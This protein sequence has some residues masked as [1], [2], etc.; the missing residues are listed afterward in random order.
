MECGCDGVMVC[1]SA[2]VWVCGSAGVMGCW[3]DGVRVCWGDEVPLSFPRRRE[4]RPFKKDKRRGWIPA[5]AG[6]TK[7]KS[8][9]DKRKKRE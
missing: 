3:G 4:S 6:M 5:S 9:N 7:E 1:W 2:G 8:G